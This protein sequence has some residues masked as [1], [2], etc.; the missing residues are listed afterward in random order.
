MSI[1]FNFTKNGLE[2]RSVLFFFRIEKSLSQLKFH[3]CKANI[4]KFKNAI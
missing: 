3:L 2:Y 4:C 1:D